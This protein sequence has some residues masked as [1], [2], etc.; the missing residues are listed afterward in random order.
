MITKKI[1]L[2]ILVAIAMATIAICGS[3]RAKC[4]NEAYVIAKGTVDVSIL[5]RTVNNQIVIEKDVDLRGTVCKLPKGKTLVIKKGTIRN[6]TLI[7]NNTQLV[8]KQDAF[9]KVTIQGTWDV[10][11][12]ST[13]LFTDLGYENSLRDV[14]ALAHPK[15]QNRIV[16]EKG[17]YK[18][19]GEKNSDVCVPICSN[20][21]LI[22][23]G[24]VK[25]V[26]NDYKSY[27]IIQAKGEN[28]SINGN[29]TIIGDKH[30]HIGTEGEWG[31]GI[32]LRGA[33]NTIVSGLTIKD[34]WGDC[35]YVGGN[36]QNVLIEKCRLDHGRRQGIS[37]TKA[38]GVT[39]RNTTITN[40]GG[41]APEFAIDIEPNRRD[42]VDNILIENVTVKGC[43]GGFLATRG[44]P[45]DGAKTPWIGGVTIRNCQVLSKS[46]RPVSVKRCEV[47][48]IEKC[49][50]YAQKGRTAITV[51]ET[52]KAI[53]QNNT[54]SIDG[55]FFEKAKNG[56]KSLIGKGM[57][58]IYVK[59]KNQSIVK[60]NKVVER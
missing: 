4:R 28:I 19:K 15:V 33:I 49:A 6:G 1:K 30:T 12:I 44:K 17:V 31:M 3:S 22:L 59:T 5:G 51:T 26:P 55:S 52:G 38:D 2:R 36:S 54:A 46:K 48:K 58:P 29:C 23:K 53:V 42:S 39:I 16:I 50:L 24:T 10:P 47:V 43:E 40:V 27:N 57:D 7:G 45:K 8:C 21:D 14:V 60:N 20:T 34:C 25:L 41:T 11:E 35:I 32:N 18:V 13:K 37:V 9:D 56:A